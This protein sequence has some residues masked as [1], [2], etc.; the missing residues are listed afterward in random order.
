MNL[1]DMGC[2][3]FISIVPMKFKDNRS[4]CSKL[5]IRNQFDNRRTDDQ[6]YCNYNTTVFKIIETSGNGK[7][8]KH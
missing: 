6:G 5:S 3:L 2:Q 1:N 4:R 8:I 7:Y